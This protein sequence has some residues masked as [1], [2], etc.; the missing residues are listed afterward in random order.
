[1]KC[2]ILQTIALSTRYGSE[3]N[4]RLLVVGYSIPTFLICTPRGAWALLY[5]PLR[6]YC[7]HRAAAD[8]AV[9]PVKRNVF[10]YGRMWR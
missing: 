7:V 1:M 4:G 9:S 6:L 3:P 10:M 2:E 8:S 5:G